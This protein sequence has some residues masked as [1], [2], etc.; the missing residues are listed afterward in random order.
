MVHTVRP[1]GSPAY[2]PQ[3][4]SVAELAAGVAVVTGRPP[5]LLLLHYGR[6]RRWCLPK[7]H[8]EP[9]ETLAAAAMRELAEETG[10]RH[11]ELGPELTE[12]HYRFFQAKRHRNSLKTTVYFVGFT[13]ERLVQP[14]PIFDA[15]EWVSLPE[16]GRRL[17]YPA[18]RLVLKALTRYLR[19]HRARR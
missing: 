8:A 7:G 17:P 3:A 10:L 11:V 12:I 4:P 13:E 16:A 18:E 19:T 5:R 1:H 6:E 2:R 9:G 14:E 15:A